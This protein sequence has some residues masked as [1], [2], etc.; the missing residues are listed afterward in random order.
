MEY[1]DDTENR[2]MQIKETRIEVAIKH[3]YLITLPN[4][5]DTIEL[6][7]IS[8]DSNDA[9]R[10]DQCDPDDRNVK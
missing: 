7:V 3:H 10:V 9:E 6:M 1:T 2:E 8:S 4:R 5:A